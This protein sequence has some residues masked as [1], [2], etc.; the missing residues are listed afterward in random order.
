MLLTIAVIDV[1]FREKKFI[2]TKNSRVRNC[3]YEGGDRI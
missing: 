3:I 1:I 2:I